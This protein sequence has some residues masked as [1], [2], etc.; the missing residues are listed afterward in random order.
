MFT[1]RRLQKV[2]GAWL[3]KGEMNSSGAEEGEAGGTVEAKAQRQQSLWHGVVH[4]EQ[5]EN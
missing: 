4:E 3:C 2:M 1:V 5:V